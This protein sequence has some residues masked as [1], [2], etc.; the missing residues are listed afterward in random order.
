MVPE[1]EAMSFGDQMTVNWFVAGVEGDPAG[2]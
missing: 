1:G 2:G